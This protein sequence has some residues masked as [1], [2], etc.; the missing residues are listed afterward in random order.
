MR[1]I[2]GISLIVL[3]AVF[4]FAFDGCGNG[5]SEKSSNVITENDLFSKPQIISTHQ[6]TIVVHLEHPDGEG[7]DRDIG[8]KGT[9]EV[10]V[11]YSEDI[12]HTFCWKNDTSD[13]GHRMELIDSSGNTVL[14]AY[15]NGECA[16][17]TVPAGHYT[18]RF[19]HGGQSEGT[20]AVFIR[21]DEDN[22]SSEDIANIATVKNNIKTIITTHSCEYC[23]LSG[24][25]L[26]G[27]NLS[28]ANLYTA[29]LSG[30]DLSATNMSYVFLP[31]ANL[32]GADL[33]MANLHMATLGST[34]LHGANLSGANLKESYLEA[35]DL[36]KAD[37]TGAD[38]SGSYYW[39]ADIS[40]ATWIDGIICAEGS[41]G[42]C[43]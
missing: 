32:T 30:A 37:L 25:N 36:R 4:L 18:I 3:M 22:D 10:T 19:T 15:S 11:Y 5:S 38:L 33:Q 20:Q 26:S 27:A 40:G 41:V 8:N 9:D 43:L 29:N 39:N 35:A 42:T 7:H 21:P 14:T 16:D 2:G 12:N 34:N 6:H 13:A 24:A 1:K 31:N 17:A 23:D 28:G